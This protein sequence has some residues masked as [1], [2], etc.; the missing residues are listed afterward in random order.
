[1]AKK[2]SKAVWL[3]MLMPVVM[4][5]SV[6]S[7]FVASSKPEQTIGSAEVLGANTDAAQLVDEDAKTGLIE[8][9]IIS[10]SAKLKRS[11]STNPISDEV[12]VSIPA[13]GNVTTPNPA[14]ARFAEYIA[15]F[16][17]AAPTSQPLMVTFYSA[18]DSS[19]VGMDT[20]QIPTL[21]VNRQS[22]ENFADFTAQLIALFANQMA[23]SPLQ[24]RSDISGAEAVRVCS[25]YLHAQTCFTE[26]SM[27]NRFY[28]SFWRNQEHFTVRDRSVGAAKDWY[29]KHSD[30]FA[31]WRAT[32]NPLDDFSQTVAWYILGSQQNDD[33]IKTQKLRFIDQFEQLR[34]YK[35]Q[36][37]AALLQ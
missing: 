24:T 4:A 34:A 16:A 2:E 12:M 27:L 10:A 14:D 13:T 35:A 9:A 29:A 5:G 28:E 25:T 8:A 32:V 20:A 3:V 17:P 11:Y 21:R 1:M 36:V 18:D 15:M 23:A 6:V 37:R 33:T 31:N 7:Y 19:L 22:T 30:D 26:Q